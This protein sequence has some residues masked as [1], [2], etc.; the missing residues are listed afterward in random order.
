LVSASGKRYLRHIN[1]KN[2]EG[3]ERNG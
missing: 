3:A 2:H 1:F